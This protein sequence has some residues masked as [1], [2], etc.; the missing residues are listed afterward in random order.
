MFDREEQKE[1]F[2]PI[3]I[4][5]LGYPQQRNVSYL[6]LVIGDENDNAMKPGSSSIFVYNYKG[7]APDT[8]IGRVFVDDLDD[9]D[10]HDKTFRW[11]D[12]SPHTYFDLNADTGMIKMLQGTR[13]G[14]YQLSFTVEEES[15]HVPYH[16]VDSEV[17]VTVKEI[18]EEAVDKSGSIRFYD[19]TAEKFI[20]ENPISHKERLRNAL[21]ELYNTSKENVDIFTVLKND[22]DSSLLD[23]R[24]SAHGSP[25]YEPE[26]LNG[27]ISQQFHELEDRLGMKMVM[28]GID[29]CLIERAKCESSC[30]NKL[31]KDSRLLSVFTNRTS[32]VG[33]NAFTRAVCECEQPKRIGEPI[34]LNGGTAYSNACDCPKGFDGP[35]CEQVTIGFTGNSW[36]LY[37]P[38]N[39]CDNTKISLEIRPA[40]N[41]ALVMYIGPMMYSPRLHVQDFLA[42]ELVDGYP[43]LIVDYG[44]GSVKIH[45]NYTQLETGKFHTIDIMLSKSGV[46]MTVDNCKLSSCMSLGAPHGKNEF[47]NVNSPISLGGASVNLDVLAAAHHWTHMPTTRGFIGCIRNLTINEQTYNLGQPSISKNIDPG[48]E[49]SLTAAVT[50]GVKNT[51]LWALLLCIILLI[52]LIF[53]VVI[54]RKTYSGVSNGNFPF[55]SR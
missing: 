3:L 15:K 55:S 11:R 12:G 43:V 34:C 28:I 25:Y 7:E 30:V 42:L 35:N 31:E 10:L 1:Y 49:T 48:C 29:E 44:T 51:F 26:K 23:V 40:T 4:N 16:N 46:E 27:K 38:I 53:A 8:E 32:F 22:A 18:P 52:V 50:F 45:H 33:V 41:D 47:L 21:A 19:I 9:W 36:A 24:F 14:I 20:E 6:H 2:I 17:T 39:P 13:E 54:H 37:P 5:D